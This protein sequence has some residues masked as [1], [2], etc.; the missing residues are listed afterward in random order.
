LISIFD[1]HELELLISGNTFY[2]LYHDD[3]MLI[4]N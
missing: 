2:L 4:I 1:E 3:N